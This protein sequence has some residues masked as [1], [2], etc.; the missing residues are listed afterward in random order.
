MKPKAIAGLVLALGILG[1]IGVKLFV[2]DS[3][4]KQ[5]VQTSDAKHLKA[6][7]RI[8]MDS[9]I[10]Y[11]QL[12]SKHFR[13]SLRNI[14][15]RSACENDNADIASRLQKLQRGDLEFAV[16]TVDAYVALGADYNFPGTIIAVIDESKGGDAMVA[17]SDIVSSIDDLKGNT[18]LRVA[19]TPDSPSEHLTRSLA[20]HFDV[21]NLKRRG[22]WLVE[23]NGSEEAL[24]MLEQG[25]VDAAVLWEPDVTRALQM[26]GVSKVIGT[27]DT[28]K[29]IVDVLLVN[30]DFLASR[31]DIVKETL[32]VYFD[33]LQF[34][35]QSPNNL[36]RELTKETGLKSSAVQSMLKG[37]KWASLSDN[38]YDWYST[39]P[40]SL[41]NE[42]LVET[43]ESAITILKETGGLS[44][45]PL[46][47][48]NPYLITH[49]EFIG[50][51]FDEK[52]GS[53]DP[54]AFSTEHAKKFAILSSDEWNELR[55]I[56][57]LKVRNVQFQ[58]SSG[59]LSMDA[60]RVLDEAAKDIAHYPNYRILIK[61]HTS[62]LG[63]PKA[64][65]VLSQDRADSVLRY[66]S[67]THGIQEA[68]LH[69][70]GVGGNEPLARLPNESNRTYRYRLPRVELILMSGDL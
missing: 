67:I 3:E 42:Y 63:D 53:V 24:K 39:A 35:R 31:P 36:V 4:S 7:V 46:P 12:C 22:K 49:S 1:L 8:G 19:L 45:N 9:W 52:V 40:Q 47:N 60:K 14:G 15:I 41:T 32:S 20:V 28:E 29:L 30:R 61:G 23:A 5:V 16:A 17:M 68:R 65:M 11:Y 70:R 62:T 43:I 21:Q 69:P 10:G 57:T 2:M 13:S 27:E 51:L 59:D 56:G 6:T 37:V 33:S 25:R 44:S 48:R 54:R 26:D 66:L 50:Q 55:E 64:N 58:S 34:Y 18:A 38:A